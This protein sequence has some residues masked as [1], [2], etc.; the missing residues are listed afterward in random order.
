MLSRGLGERVPRVDPEDAKAR[1]T[2]EQ[3]K[4]WLAERCRA[5]GDTERRMW[6]QADL[7][8]RVL[9]RWP[10]EPQAIDALARWYHAQRTFQDFWNLVACSSG[11]AELFKAWVNNGR[12]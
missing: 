6:R 10:D 4:E 1:A 5:A 3:F 8:K 7:A 2:V 11:R 9:A 12:R